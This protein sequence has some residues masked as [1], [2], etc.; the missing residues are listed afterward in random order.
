MSDEDEYQLFSMCMRVKGQE[1]SIA[2][3]SDYLLRF[4]NLAVLP[5]KTGRMEC[6]EGFDISKLKFYFEE[7]YE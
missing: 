4:V 1:I 3:M 2:N 7:P 5:H 6:D